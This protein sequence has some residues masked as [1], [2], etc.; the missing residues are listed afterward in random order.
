[1]KTF[2][3]Y[4]AESK[5][6]YAFKVKVCGDIPE[7]FLN[8]LKSRLVN[9]G[10][11]KCNEGKKMPVSNLPLDF[12][13]V[14][15]CDVT[16]YEVTTEYPITPQEIS[17]H[18]KEMNCCAEGTYTVKNA[19]DPTE[20]EQEQMMLEKSGESLLGSDYVGKVNHKDY[21]GDDFNKGF[22]QELQKASKER[23][24]ELGHDA[25]GMK[26]VDVLG[27]Q[28][29]FETDKAGCSSPVGSK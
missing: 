2:R 24:K 19:A 20:M 29:K 16:V 22:L 9:C 15:D 21:F 12:P 8:D 6:E 10:E 4:L 23:N 13:E 11:C 5:K 17:K 3:E 26:D 7:N 28:P 27:S 1:M 14:K 18:I 25:A